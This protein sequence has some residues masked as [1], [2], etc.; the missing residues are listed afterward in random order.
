M[1]IR[2]PECGKEV[3][4]QSEKC[5]N[6]GYPIKVRDNKYKVIF[7]K[8]NDTDAAAMAGLK[9]VLKMEDNEISKIINNYPCE[10]ASFNSYEHANICAIRLS[11]WHIDASLLNPNKENM[12]AD[13][14][15]VFCPYCECTNIQIVQRKWSIL[16]GFLT[17]KSDRV[18]LKCNTKF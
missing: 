9:V 12:P 10:I 3:S 6:C 16:T 15:M 14:T 4:D 13:H 5:I 11:K 18:C 7:N 2:C 8:F 1:L 17:N